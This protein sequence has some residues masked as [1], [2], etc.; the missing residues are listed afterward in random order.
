MSAVSFVL[1]LFDVAEAKS[2]A[3][4]R[5]LGP[6]IAI[7]DA[8]GVTVARSEPLSADVRRMITQPFEGERSAGLRFTAKREYHVAR[9]EIRGIKVCAIASQRTDI[10]CKLRAKDTLDFTWVWRGTL[11]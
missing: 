1:D 8:F 11:Q 10:P 2:R 6:H 4:E 7:V 9:A 5:N 3:H